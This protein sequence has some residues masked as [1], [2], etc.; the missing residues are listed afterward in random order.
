MDGFFGNIVGIRTRMSYYTYYRVEN[1]FLSNIYT[2]DLNIIEY[3]DNFQ[4]VGCDIPGL[5]DVEN[6]LDVGDDEDSVPG[7]NIENGVP[8]LDDEDLSDLDEDD[9]PGLVYYD[10]ILGW[11]DYNDDI[12]KNGNINEEDLCYL[13]PVGLRQG[14]QP[15]NCK[16]IIT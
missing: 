3:I 2:I 11:V 5:G 16:N 6:I 13:I 15:N 1:T 4:N 9:L 12:S 7:L 14:L 8:D 10:D